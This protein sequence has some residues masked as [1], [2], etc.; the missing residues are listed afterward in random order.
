MK[1][2]YHA[3]PRANPPSWCSGRVTQ[4][5][6]HCNTGGVDGLEQV[7]AYLA[8]ADFEEREGLWID[9]EEEIGAAPT[10]T[11]VFIGWLDVAWPSPS[12]P[13]HE[14][15]DVVHLPLPGAAERLSRTIDSARA[16]ARA[17]LRECRHCRSQVTPGH[18]ESDDVCQACAERQLGVVH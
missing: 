12:S 9:R 18:M 2:G 7:M 16:H 14:L 5:R 17:E 10:R 13:V 15:K 4:G 6:A 1:G 3:Q 8:A 11:G